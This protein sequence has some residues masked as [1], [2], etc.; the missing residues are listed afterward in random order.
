MLNTLGIKQ[1]NP[2][3]LQFS[4]CISGG[5]RQSPP[6]LSSEA[7]AAAPFPAGED[8][9]ITQLLFQG[10][11]FAQPQPGLP[12]NNLPFHQGNSPPATPS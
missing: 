4:P 10:T 8:N 5:G 9:R 12:A 11:P 2:C 6:L 3:S 7:E 1:L